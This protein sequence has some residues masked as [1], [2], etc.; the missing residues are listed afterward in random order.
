MD[1]TYSGR[2][3]WHRAVFCP[4]VA[5][6]AFA[7]LGRWPSC[8]FS[9]RSLD[10]YLDDTL[11]LQEFRNEANQADLNLSSFSDLEAVE[12]RHLVRVRPGLGA[13]MQS[14]VCVI[15]LRQPAL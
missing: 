12:T 10:P 15:R 6:I 13:Y 14:A 11:D 2:V 9:R 3:L 4:G 7:V 5:P 8:L 1:G